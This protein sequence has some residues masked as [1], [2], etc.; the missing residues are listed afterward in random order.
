MVSVEGFIEK[1]YELLWD[2]DGEVCHT[3][4]CNESSCY[5]CIKKHLKQDLTA[6][7]KQEALKMLPFKI[8]NPISEFERGFGACIDIIQQ[9][10]SNYTIERSGE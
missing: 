10:I 8:H 6:L 1:W 3:K 2:N 4:E 9:N 7:I 5:D